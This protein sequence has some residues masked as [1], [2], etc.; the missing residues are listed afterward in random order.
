MLQN[1]DSGMKLSRLSEPLVGEA[2]DCEGRLIGSDPLS[3]RQRA[4][5]ERRLSLMRKC[6]KTKDP[7]ARAEWYEF[8]ES[9]R[10]MVG[11]QVADV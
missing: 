7:K 2:Y 6:L 9:L 8:E 3:P 5:V 10:E 1:P 4:V 11:T